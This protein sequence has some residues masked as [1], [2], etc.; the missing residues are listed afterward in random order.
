[1]AR[2]Q[3]KSVLIPLSDDQ[4]A[5][6][7]YLMIRIAGYFHQAAGHGI[8]RSGIA[9]H[10]LL[11]C[12]D[13]KGWADI[14][15]KKTD[16]GRGDIVYCPANQPYGYGCA[17]EDPWSIL[18]FHFTGAGADYFEEETSAG[19]NYGVVS[20]GR[21]PYLE[22]QFFRVFSCLEK[23]DKLVE[24]LRAEAMFQL[25]LCQVCDMVRHRAAQ[26]P[27]QQQAYVRQAEQ[28]IEAHYKED[29]SLDAMSEYVGLSKYYLIHLFREHTGYTPKEYCLHL[30]FN[31]ACRLLQETSL[32]IRDISRISCYSNPY[33]FSQGFKKFTGYSPSQFRQLLSKNQTLK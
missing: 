24:V 17:A 12:V 20:L 14:H 3:D 4:N 10:V 21:Q 22:E 31:E 11:Y 1:M 6:N 25:V 13:G 27:S 15:G 16:I 8:Y 33:H 9:E 28:F 32:P 2:E 5:E 19:K 18:W 7:R 23:S 29:I 30:R 26:E